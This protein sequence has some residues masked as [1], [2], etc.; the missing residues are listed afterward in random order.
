[1]FLGEV[2]SNEHDLDPSSYNKVISD[3]D[4][5]NWQ[6]ATKVEDDVYMI[7]SYG[8]IAKGQGIWYASCIDPFGDLSKPPEVRT[9]IL[10]RQSNL[11]ILNKIC[12]NHVCIKCANKTWW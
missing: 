12:I 10:I 3:N 11:L 7:E 9:F 6:N 2:V 4:L 8:F 1:M 5:K